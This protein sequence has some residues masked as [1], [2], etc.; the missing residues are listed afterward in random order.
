MER[1]K[2]NSIEEIWDGKKLIIKDFSN[3]DLEGLDLSVIPP[4]EWYRCIINNT[5]FKN[6]G[7]KLFFHGMPNKPIKNCDFSYNDSFDL[8][9]IDTKYFDN[10]DFRE[11][12]TTDDIFGKNNY[13]DKN[14]K[15]W[16]HVV[17][18]DMLPIDLGTLEKNPQLE[19]SSTELLYIILTNVTV[20]KEE[21]CISLIEEFLKYDKQGD[22]K[23]LYDILKNE[24]MEYEIIKLFSELRILNVI[25][26]DINFE[27]IDYTLLGAINFNNC[28]FENLTLEHNLKD[29][30]YIP[31]NTFN[32]SNK[33]SEINTPNITYNS[34]QEDHP[35]KTRVSHSPMTF[36]TN[37]YLELGRLCN[38]RCEFCRNSYYCDNMYDFDNISKTLRKVIPK[39]DSVVIGGGEPS[40]RLDDL[41]KL[42]SNSLEAIHRNN[43][44]IYLFTNGTHKYIDEELAPYNVKYNISRHAVNDEENAAIF[45]LPSKKILSSEE[46][47]WFIYQNPKTTLAATCFKGALDSKQKIIDY[48]KYAAN[49]GCQSILFSDLIVMEDELLKTKENYNFNI[50]S[51]VFDEVISYLQKKGYEKSIPIYGT[52]GYM[53]TM[54]KK[55][56]MN[57][58]FK[59]YISKRELEE[60]WS[61][62]IKRTFD[63]SIDPNGNLYENWHQTSGL[64]KNIKKK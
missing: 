5:S 64:V 29:L 39:L 20:T 24:L 59:H 56:D 33:F 32:G 7:V 42:I 47:K 44:G 30:L 41:K 8:L 27:D 48:I 18:Y 6:T 9:G 16:S 25:F 3:L 1:K 4:R 19:L 2:V 53:L 10:C 46:L 12:N 37:L 51:S 40:L 49:T 23:K 45:K 31:N 50:E 62:A 26:K 55:G 63:L 60:N 15:S 54:L 38:A 13:L 36:R 28:E 57:I 21:K 17:G 14:F 43:V 58:S 35:S 34:W 61:K 22:L 52:G 11:T